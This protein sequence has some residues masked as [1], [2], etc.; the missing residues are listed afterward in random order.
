MKRRGGD[1]EGGGGGEVAGLVEFDEG[2]V[3]C[4]CAGFCA[5]CV[6]CLLQQEGARCKEERCSRGKGANAACAAASPTARARPDHPTCPRPRSRLDRP[7][8][9]IQRSQHRFL[10]LV[11][12]RTAP[13]PRPQPSRL[14]RALTRLDRFLLELSRARP[15]P[16]SS[17]LALSAMTRRSRTSAL[18]GAGPFSPGRSAQA[19]LCSSSLESSSRSAAAARARPEQVLLA[20]D[21]HRHALVPALAAA[22][23]LTLA[24]SKRSRRS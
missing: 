14:H 3:A 19:R 18:G 6:C 21:R 8:S 9:S 5:V 12:L 13:T 23:L 16:S 17:A 1:E 24:E 2:R 15:T 4:G 7:R 20:P 22:A 11:K 10:D